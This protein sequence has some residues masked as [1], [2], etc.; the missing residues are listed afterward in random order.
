MTRWVNLC[1]VHVRGPGVSTQVKSIVEKEL[2]INAKL[3]DGFAF[4]V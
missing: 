1:D 3:R 2:K 4:R